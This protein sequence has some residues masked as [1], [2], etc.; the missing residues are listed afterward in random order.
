ME[1]IMRTPNNTTIVINDN[2]VVITNSTGERI[3]EYG[4][5]K[6][7]IAMNFMSSIHYFFTMSEY[8][9]TLVKEWVTNVKPETEEEKAFIDR[10]SKAIETVKY[11]YKIA[12]IEPS[13]TPSGKLVYEVGKKVSIGID[14]E[15]WEKKAKEF[16]KYVDDISDIATLEEYDMFIAYRIAANFW[17]LSYVCNDSSEFGNYYDSPN[18]SR[19]MDA[20]GTKKVGG[21]FDGVGNTCK[22]VKSGKKYI[23]C[24]GNFNTWGCNYPVA[25]ITRYDDI[26]GT[27]VGCGTGVVVIKAKNEV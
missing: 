26:D 11:D 25:D 17:S 10:V 19:R 1:Q 22:I 18:G 13:V 16:C 14:F 15:E 6:R 5:S 21:F 7:I 20:S 4:D 27:Y 8:E 24:G 2:T 23:V 9:R 12:T 3:Y